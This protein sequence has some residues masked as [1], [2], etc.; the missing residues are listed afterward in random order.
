[1]N[2]NRSLPAFLLA[3]LLGIQPIHLAHALNI[4]QEPLFL[5]QAQPPLVM[6]NMARDHRLYYESYDDYSDLDGDGLLDV[7]Y[8]PSKIN[9]YGYFDSFK[10]YQYDPTNRRFNPIS[11]TPNKKCGG[12]HW[13]GDF[14]N[15]LTTSRMDALRKVLYGGFRRTDTTALTVLERVFIPQDAHAWGKE[16]V[17]I[18]RD[19]YDISDYAPFSPPAPGRRHIFA[20]VTLAQNDQTTGDTTHAS[21][22]HGV[23]STLNATAGQEATNPPLLRVLLNTD[24]RVWDWMSKERP[25]AGRFC[26]RGTNQSGSCFGSTAAAGWQ[27]VPSSAFTGLNASYYSA[28]N[29]GTVS[30]TAQ[31]EALRVPGNLQGARPITRIDC[32]STE[33]VTV[34]D[35]VTGNTVTHHADCNPF[36]PGRDT[37]DEN[38][39]TEVTGSI[40]VPTTG[41]Y[42]FAIDGDD[43]IELR[44]GTT[45]VRGLYGNRT[46]SPCRSSGEFDTACSGNIGSIHLTA[47]THNLRFRHY[48]NTG[49]DGYRLWW[50]VA[51]AASTRHNYEVR[52]RVCDAAVGLE[53]NCKAYSDGATVTYKPTGLL[54]TYG[55]NN[56]MFFGLMT[57]SYRNNTEGG[58]LRKNISAFQDEF[59][60]STGIFTGVNGI[61]R[62]I[63][64]LRITGF[65][66]SDWSYQAGSPSG[67]CGWIANRQMNNTECEMWGNPLGEMIWETLRYFNGR[68][69]PTPAFDYSGTTVDANTLGLPKPAWWDPYSAAAGRN[70]P[71]A[72][73]YCAR[74]HVLA[75]S[76]S[77]PSFDSNAIPGSFFGGV[78]SD[79]VLG[80]G[81]TAPHMTS[82]GSRLWNFEFNGAIR[83][84]FIGQSGVV[85]DSA[86]TSKLVNSFGNIRGLAPSDPTRQGSYSSSL[87]AYWGR[88]SDVRPD[89]MGRQ[90]T[91][92]Y[93]V[94]LAPP[95]P[96]IA[97]PIP[98]SS[99][100][101]MI[102]PFAKSVGGSGISHA[103][104]AFQPTNQIVDF[105]VDTIVNTHPG[106]ADPSINGGRPFYRFRINYEDVEQGADHDMDAIAIYEIWLNAD[107]T[108]SVNLISEYA[109]GGIMQHMGYVI[110]GTGADGTYLVIRDLDTAAGSDPDYFLDRPP[111]G[112]APGRTGALP[113]TYPTAVT[114]GTPCPNRTDNF[115]CR[116]FTPST[117]AASSILLKDP[118][119]YAAKW[120]GFSDANNNALPEGTEWDADNNAVPD[121]YFL[122]VNPL[123]LE[124]EM[125]AA[126]AKIAS[127]SGTAAALA[128]NS[129]SLRTDLILYQARFSSDGWGGELNAFP[130][131]SDGELDEPRWQAQYVMAGIPSISTRLNPATRVVLTF[132]PDALP[133]SRGIPFRWTSMSAGGRLRD[134]L[135]RRWTTGGGSVDGRG[136]ERVDYLRGA[137][138]AGFRTRP[139]IPGTAGA[140]CIIN[141]LGAI[142][143]SSILYVG[144]PAFGYSLPHYGQFF[145]DRRNRTPMVYVGGNDG[146]L[147]GFDANTG[148]EKLAYV[149]SPLYRHARLSKLTAPD[150]GNSTN[151]HAYFVDG[152]PTIGDICVGSCASHNDWRTIL[153]GGLG[154]GGQGIYALNIT[155]PEDFSEANASSLVLWEFNDTHDADL[156]YTF[157]RPA[158]VRMCTS[159]DAA[160]MANPK[161][162]VASQWVVVFGNGYN[163]NESDG[164][165]GAGRATLFVLDAATGTLLR[166]IPYTG[167]GVPNGFGNFSPADMDGDGIVDFAYAGDLFGN[168]VKFDLQT[169]SGGAVAY[170]LYTARHGAQVQPITSAPELIMHPNGGVMV[171]FG[172]G[173]YLEMT[174][175]LST[176]QQTF[177]GIRDTGVPVPSLADRSNLQ[178]QTLLA[179]SIVVE[180]ATLTT[181][182]ANQVNWATRNGWFLDL[183][184]DG[185]SPSERVAHDPQLLGRILNFVTVIPSSDVCAY[186]GDSWDYFLDPITGGS[187]P[188]AIFTGAETIMTT[189]GSF[190]PSRRK[191][192]V[193]I[194]PAGLIITAGRGVGIDFKGGATGEVEKF[195][196]TLRTAAGARLS[197]REIRTD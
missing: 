47:G 38:Y 18:A 54:H 135:N 63:D 173:K 33:S 93:S 161:A 27:V 109:A 132:D 40:T 45:I 142:I 71:A 160:S 92:F 137:N 105:Y 129:T 3:L 36:T 184:R 107:H 185:V 136:S 25:V 181:S 26:Q 1:M 165:A 179:G 187:P 30:N 183:S 189:A 68:T 20:N 52:V 194:A 86:P 176:T 188:Y 168:M 152:T 7:G 111:R 41:T 127:D 49:E 98:N 29:A 78:A 58:V 22:G 10:C 155:R 171:L 83:D 110:S 79:L 74:P 56:G 146:M 4:A 15:Y 163:N 53:P 115:A 174:D 57:G 180:G 43:A 103:A 101:V 8:E 28:T 69:T 108:V 24:L 88:T 192:T 178:A 87:L 70:P 19:G 190:F 102:V 104:T 9:Y 5:T 126:L 35:D 97:V 122:V 177:Y 130:I 150:Y 131:R 37:A 14:L 6:I 64:R 143:H 55:A 193:G 12:A 134:S 197:W 175:K 139:C 84:V 112:A 65:R 106:N 124:R 23:Y 117:T 13:S 75:I 172:T 39:F 153:V 32:D 167:G 166:E 46:F 138:V 116:T 147:H 144:P 120:G 80:S 149:P 95:L 140:T 94:A 11:V 17:S 164:H 133:G 195:E 123:K 156:G 169:V 125:A 145:A 50:R 76:D 59:S 157:S 114:P 62:T 141:Q 182:T 60:P 85:S 66:Y 151:P 48:E 34:I 72:L 44:I 162:C 196:V 100:R 158:I 90:E 51:S 191:S 170:T 148:V 186:G 119:W 16:Y 73:P 77:Y 31:L 159:R 128:A 82:L 61:V 91:G 2:A 81:T 113:L 96:T 99:H 89:L 118:L 154:G 121:N 42:Q 67:A 21:G